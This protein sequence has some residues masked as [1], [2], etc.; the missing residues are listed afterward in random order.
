MVVGNTFS[1]N[2]V[3]KF[4]TYVLFQTDCKT[5]FCFLVMEASILSSEFCCPFCRR[6]S[7]HM[8]RCNGA[9]ETPAA[10]LQFVHAYSIRLTDAYFPKYKIGH[11]CTWRGSSATSLLQ[12]PNPPSVGEV[13]GQ[14]NATL[15]GWPTL[16]HQIIHS[17][18]LIKVLTL[19][20]RYL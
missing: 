16:I 2:T 19:H 9:S 15:T 13:A 3:A 1:N 12:I 17:P 8:D 7:S 6:W 5:V 18:R 10:E 14:S 4:Q 11:M 20:N